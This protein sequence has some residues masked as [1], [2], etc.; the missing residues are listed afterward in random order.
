MNDCR[1]FEGC[2]SP[3]CPLQE[4][5]VQY[6][7]WYAD[8][9]IC[10]ARKFQKLP[11]VI[12]QKRIVKQGLTYEDGY[13]NV[14]MLEAIQ[15]VTKGLKGA[16]PDDVKSENRWFLERV[17]MRERVSQKRAYNKASKEKKQGVL[18]L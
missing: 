8:E 9:G 5:T 1:L 18:A 16:D 6:G 11:W 2:E 7:I 3:L 17:K 14:R 4:N 13:F 15:A 10:K 12:R